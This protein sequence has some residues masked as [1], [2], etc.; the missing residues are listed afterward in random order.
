[1]FNPT[2]LAKYSV[3]RAPYQ[4]LGQP[5]TEKIFVVIFHE[6]LFAICMKATSQTA[7][8]ENSKEMKAGVVYYKSGELPFFSVN[9]AIQPDNLHPIPHVHMAKCHLN[10][11]LKMLGQMPARFP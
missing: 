10:S 4:Y 7:L 1:V 8:Y 6:K 5:N 2:A 11:S 9:T 3:F